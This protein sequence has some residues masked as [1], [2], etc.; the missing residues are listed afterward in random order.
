M[1][2]IQ[3]KGDVK[4]G[5]ERIWERDTF[6]EI[7]KELIRENRKYWA[8]KS[9]V[10]QGNKWIY[11]YHGMSSAHFDWAV[12]EDIVAKG[13]Q[14]KTHLPIVSVI[15]GYGC[16][17]PEGLDESFGINITTHLLYSKYVSEHSEKTIHEMAKAMAE[18]TY[19]DRDKL[20]ALEHRG[21]KFGDELYDHILMKDWQNDE[22]SFDVFSISLD[23]YA[24]HI[25]NALSMIDHTFE[26]FS[27]RRPA[28]VITTEKI[29]L[30]RLFG[31]IARLFGAEEIIVLSGWPGVLMRIPSDRPQEEKVLTSSCMQAAVK[32]YI[33]H[34][35]IDIEK[36]NNLFVVDN[37]KGDQK[38]FDL[39]AQL[40]LS[41]QSKN[42]FIL[43]H[44][45]VDAPRESYQLHFYHDYLEWFLKTV[46]IIKKIPNVNWIIKDHPMTAYYKQNEYIKKVFMENKTPNMYWCD[47]NVSG[48][49]I[50]EYADCIVTCGGEAALEYW[51]Y[52]V[53]TVTTAVTYFT[54]EG[55]SYNVTSIEKYEKT[56][57]NITNLEKPAERSMKKAR[58]V[59]VAMKQMSN[60]SMQNEFIN[61]L[62]NTRKIQLGNYCSG[63]NF[64][65]IPVFCEGFIK[66][67]TSNAIEQSC[68]YQV[69]NICNLSL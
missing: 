56:L 40:G 45:F 46:E 39:V 5:T 16:T 22:P 65:H 61:L 7:K 12:R 43:P 20:L 67:L 36:A 21:I 25:R 10:T 27:Q 59:L 32:Y 31:D 52:G 23:Q 15:D 29:H 30:K 54:G 49:H 47:C 50:K 9:N 51:S 41:R 33:E 44:A 42:V 64:D 63:L 28:Y 11:V 35:K 57:K 62:I 2:R 1:V 66:L 26:L 55:I 18:A 24:H 3:T 69:E 14:K 17:L 4:M 53:P 60:C 34:K 13:L 68:I 58:E 8:S 38:T 19:K 48:M 6:S 37:N